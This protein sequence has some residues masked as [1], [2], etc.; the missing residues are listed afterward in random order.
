[1]GY[2][3]N[4]APDVKRWLAQLE[5]DQP[6]IARSVNQALETLKAKGEQVGPPLVVPVAYEQR[7]HEV[8]PE[9]ERTYRRQLQALAKLRREAAE[10]ATLRKRLEGLLDDATTDDQR[11]RLR[12]AH[13]G[14]RA[15]EERITEVCIRVHRDVQSFRVRRETLRASLTEAIIDGLTM[16]ADMAEVMDVPDPEQP[17]G[18]LMELRPGAPEG[19]VARVLFTVGPGRSAQLVG[20]ATERDVLGAWYDRVV[21][22]NDAAGN[23][24]QVAVQ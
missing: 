10:V 23:A 13:E 20:A 14:I 9:L 2:D 19:I 15:Q 6:E 12:S 11:Q 24:P 5:A 17:G 22:P 3:L 21:P 8:A 18:Q 4:F 7:H 16:L 1:M